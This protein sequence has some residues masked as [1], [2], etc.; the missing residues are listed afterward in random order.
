MHSY[1]QFCST[2][3]AQVLVV[4]YSKSASYK[5]GHLIREVHLICQFLRYV[6][7]RFDSK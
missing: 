1:K 7:I 2:Q 4:H 5:W 3:L 6:I